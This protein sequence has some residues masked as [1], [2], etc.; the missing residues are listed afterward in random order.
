MLLFSLGIIW[1]FSLNFTKRSPIS[2][3]WPRIWQLFWAKKLD[4]GKWRKWIEPALWI[5]CLTQGSRNRLL[6]TVVGQN[7]LWNHCRE[8]Q[9]KGYGYYKITHFFI[10]SQYISPLFNGFFRWEKKITSWQLGVP[11]IFNN[12]VKTIVSETITKQ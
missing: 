8:W 3:F 5:F 11:L 1:W 4:I 9:R 10:Y 7:K 6:E 2:P 12:L